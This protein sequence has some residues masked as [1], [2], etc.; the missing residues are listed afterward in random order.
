MAEHVAD[1]EHHR[2]VR[3]HERLVPVAADLCGFRRGAVAHGNLQPRRRRGRAQQG[4]LKPVG[5]GPGLGLARGEPLELH[6]PVL[7]GDAGRDVQSAEE[8]V[9]DLAG[10]VPHR[11]NGGRDV[12]LPPGGVRRPAPDR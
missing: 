9:A 10:L 3:L 8:Q 2:A 1:H 5:Q 6:G 12:A 4:L 11:V 7:R